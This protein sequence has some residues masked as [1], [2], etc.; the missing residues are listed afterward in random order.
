MKLVDEL[1]KLNADA[2]PLL[3]RLLEMGQWSEARTVVSA[4]DSAFEGH[5]DPAEVRRQLGVM[6]AAIG[7]NDAAADAVARKR[8]TDG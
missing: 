4:V 3:R 8:E 5:A 7:H 6:R 2:W 1:L